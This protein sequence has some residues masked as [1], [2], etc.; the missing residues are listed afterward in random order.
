MDSFA[1]F[2]LRKRS[3]YHGGV[4]TIVLRAGHPQHLPLSGVKSGG[5]TCQHAHT[6]VALVRAAGFAV[7]TG[8]TGD[9]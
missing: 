1:C 4:S 6:P 3:R 7:A 5:A 9:K 2:V 8:V